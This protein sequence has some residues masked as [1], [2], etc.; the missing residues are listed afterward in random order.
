LG[1]LDLKGITP[2]EFFREVDNSF[3]LCKEINNYDLITSYKLPIYHNDP[4]DRFLIWEA[5]KSDFILISADK[6][7]NQ[8]KKDGL[9]VVY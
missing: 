7:I 6:N 2:E 3:Y 1:K 9:K 5:I 4:F 8:Y